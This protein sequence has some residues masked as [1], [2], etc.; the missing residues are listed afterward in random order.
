MQELELGRLSDSE[1]GP[2]LV[3]RQA[4]LPWCRRCAKSLQGRAPGAPSAPASVAALGSE[5][6]P[7]LCPHRAR[8]PLGL[9]LESAP[10]PLPPLWWSGVNYVGGTLLRSCVAGNAAIP[11][12]FPLPARRFTPRRRDVQSSSRNGSC[13]GEPY[14][15]VVVWTMEQ[16]PTWPGSSGPR[17]RAVDNTLLREQRRPTLPMIAALVPIDAGR[18]RFHPADWR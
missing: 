16:G 5:F 14:G 18:C 6:A 12:A 8:T 11:A 13:Y 15:D 4:P 2:E 1:S 3:L 7:R 10:L 9:P 17:P